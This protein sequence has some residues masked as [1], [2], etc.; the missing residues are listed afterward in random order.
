MATF[1][2]NSSTKA[3][4][5]WTITGG[6][7]GFVYI[8]KTDSSFRR[9]TKQNMYSLAVF[10]FQPGTCQEM[11]DYNV[12]LKYVDTHCDDKKINCDIVLLWNQKVTYCWFSVMLVMAAAAVHAAPCL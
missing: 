11:Y 2:L 1:Q 7:V 10:S 9:E 12:T 4:L 8:Y 5:L 3:C 6:L